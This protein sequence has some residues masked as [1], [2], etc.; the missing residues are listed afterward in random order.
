M[1]LLPHHVDRSAPP[2][3]CLHLSGVIRLALPGDRVVV[4]P[5]MLAWLCALVYAEGRDATPR[6]LVMER[7]WAEP[8]TADRGRRR[9][10]QLVHRLNRLVEGVNVMR[11]QGAWIAPCL[12]LG[13]PL[14]E[15]PPQA[16]SASAERWA[17]SLARTVKARID[18]TERKSSVATSIREAAM[19][20]LKPPYVLRPETDQASRQSR[21]AVVTLEPFDWFMVGRIRQGEGRFVEALS[22][23]RRAER[24][25]EP[26]PGQK[27]GRGRGFT[28]T[29]LPMAVEI[30]CRVVAL[31][32]CTGER[33]VDSA[34]RRLRAA[35]QGALERGE[36]R[37]GL[38]VRQRIIEL[39]SRFS[40]YREVRRQ[41]D[42]LGRYAEG[43]RR[44]GVHPDALRC[45]YGNFLSHDVRPTEIR[46]VA[47]VAEQV[48]DFRSWS[49]VEAALSAF[50]R[51]GQL[52]HETP[53]QLASLMA[54]AK[55][56]GEGV[57]TLLRIAVLLAIWHLR[58][59]SIG[60]AAQQV[61]RATQVATTT[62]DEALRALAFTA[63]AQMHLQE[64]E[65]IK[66]ERAARQAAE[67][68]ARA[69]QGMRDEPVESWIGDRVHA[70]RGLVALEQGSITKAESHAAGMVDAETDFH[71]PTLKIRLRARLLARRQ[72]A[73]E[74]VELVT[75]ALDRLRSRFVPASVELT[76]ELGQLARRAK[77]SVCRARL[78][79]AMATAQRC[80]M[81]TEAKRL[82]IVIE[83][84]AP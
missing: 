19:L 50:S 75:A 39:L 36:E 32:A 42:S 27:R 45:R 61:E 10:N 68:Y 2:E 24:A 7:L 14:T 8:A 41:V 77:V 46:S 21:R 84:H 44:L 74:A 37:V 9:L 4:L 47:G 16:P 23:V 63:S 83:A 54:H 26:V 18:E 59:D 79:E 15:V 11:R 67:H 64:G 40:R 12:P 6:D 57:G 78:T 22:M 70:L 55:D 53:L 3:P 34:V 43:E 33:S 17:E 56:G 48:P 66:A 1:N 51:R 38:E 30:R 13:S 76:V 60:V 28:K 52:R 72:R 73:A 58:T 65:I 35:E 25:L 80:G 29:A 62:H 81:N 82:R 31:E 71:D 49:L 69:S 20:E 5:P